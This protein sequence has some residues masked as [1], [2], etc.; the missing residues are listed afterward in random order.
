MKISPILKRLAF[1]FGLYLIAI[2]VETVGFGGSLGPYAVY[3]SFAC[4][5]I[6]FA[7]GGMR[8]PIPTFPMALMAIYLV[9]HV[10]CWMSS[11]AMVGH[12]IFPSWFFGALWHYFLRHREKCRIQDGQLG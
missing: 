12:S 1:P 5:V 11:W 3:L 7:L 2:Y 10:D 4:Y 6:A 9:P 8:A